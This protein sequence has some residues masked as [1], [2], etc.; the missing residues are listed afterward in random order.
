MTARRKGLLFAAAALVLALLC[1]LL[2]FNLKAVS[3]LGKDWIPLPEP[4]GSGDIARD[5]TLRLEFSGLDRRLDRAHI[6]IEVRD[7]KG[8]LVPTEL[9][10]FLSDEGHRSFYEA[11]SVSY[12][13][14]HDKGA[15]FS[16]NSY[17]LARGLRLELKSPGGGGAYRLLAAE[18]NGSVPFRFSLRRLL[19]LWALLLL[20]WALRPGSRL[21]DN[22]HWN[23]RRWAKALCVLLALLLNLG[24]L[25]GLVGTNRA[26]VDIS[27]EARWAHHRQ[28][29]RLARS[30]AEGRLSIETPEDSEALEK[31]A[32]ME[33]PYDSSSRHALRDREGTVFPWDTAYYQG[34]LYVYFGAAPV[35]LCYLPWYLLTGQDLPT[36][37]AVLL[38][39]SL[40]VL[41]AFACLRALIRRCFP[42]TPFPVYL[43]LSLLLGNCTGLLYYGLEPSFYVVPV[44]FALAFSLLALALWISAAQRWALA[45]DGSVGG[46]GAE[47]HCFA[48]LT[49]PGSGFG[50][51]LRIALGALLA[52]LTA[53][54]RPQFLVFSVL[55]LPILWPLFRAEK[56]GSVRLRSL[57][58]FALPYGLV[59][60]PL[61]Y[62]N[63]LRFGSPFDFGA[64]Y[65]LTTNDMTH[66]GWRWG[67]L[68]DGFFAYLLQPPALR[69][70]FPYFFPVSRELL[71]NGKTI[72]EDMFG[73][74]LLISPFLWLLLRL[75]RARAALRERKLW[76]LTLLPLLL[77]VAVIAAD[78]EMAGILWRYTCD[79]L[80]LL[81]LAAIL[82]FLALLRKARHSERRRLLRFLVFAA[83]FTLASSLLISVNSSQLLTRCPEAYYRLRDFLSWG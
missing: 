18:I 51:R 30:L 10:V 26:F 20:L 58:C 16:L 62:Y 17:G 33:N 1:E 31:L 76:A 74:V 55:A 57:L 5:E 80:A 43:L 64:N 32:A 67:R 38:A 45:Q 60:A 65:N 37:W 39:F 50:I 9:T 70:A 53:A 22:R 29:A 75:R 19:G 41:A 59:A 28:Y 82:V 68:P 69:L 48:P 61:M 24:L 13:P 52:A 79:Y 81:Y 42:E 66:R 27:D 2:V 23:R 36:V 6:L 78:T 8:A 12:L 77:T 56:R 25:Y 3:S 35:L 83:I 14:G 21:Y 47:A 63:K 4:V 11:G 72:A 73:G 49:E 54:C 34:H 7:G 44:F 46:I 15:Y 40:T 71:Y